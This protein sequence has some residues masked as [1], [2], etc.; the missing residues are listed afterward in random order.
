MTTVRYSN[1]EYKNGASQATKNARVVPSLIFE[2][3]RIK[4]KCLLILAMW[5]CVSVSMRVC[6]CVSES[7]ECVSVSASV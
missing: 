1:A 4:P 3:E 6:E 2:I 5:V 7:A